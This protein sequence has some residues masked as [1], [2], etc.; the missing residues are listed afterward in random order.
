LLCFLGWAQLGGLFARNQLVS[1]EFLDSMTKIIVPCFVALT[2]IDS[3][4]KLKQLAWVI[5][6]SIGY[7]AFHENEAYFSNPLVHRDNVV[8]HTMAIGVSVA[9]FLG[10]YS[11]YWWQSI[12]A[13]FC[14]AVMV[15][16]VEIHNSRGAMLGILVLG[17]GTFALMERKPRHYWMFALGLLAALWLAG[18]AVQERFATIFASEEQRDASAESRLQFW[19]G[20]LRGIRAHPVLGVGPDHWHLVSEEYGLPAHREGHN[21]WLQVAAEHG[22]PG[23]AA[24]VTFYLLTV[25]RL[26]PLARRKEKAADPWIGLLACTV[27]ATILGYMTEAVFG[28]FRTLEAA[29]YVAIL[30]AGA[31]M[32]QDRLKAAAAPALP[33]SWQF[34][35]SMPGPVMLGSA[36]PLASSRS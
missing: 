17:L 29:Y 23:I 3:V 27:L 32:M 8:A 24:L 14:A 19:A 28:S 9:F 30:G 4:A 16:G 11:Q 25:K 7:V 26:L 10:L 5:T 18:P 22:L 2:L 6:L 21:L 13:Y 1:D 20:M 34:R 35:R 12:L 15:H 33:A 31:L 36:G